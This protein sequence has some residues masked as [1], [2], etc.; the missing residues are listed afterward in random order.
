MAQGVPA[1]VGFIQDDNFVAARR[2][3]HLLLSK[4]LDLVAHH[5]NAP[6]QHR[7]P[8]RAHCTLPAAQCRPGGAV[9]HPSHPASKKAKLTTVLLAIQTGSMGTGHCRLAQ[10]AQAVG[11]SCCALCRIY[12][13]TAGVGSCIF[14]HLPCLSCVGPDEACRSLQKHQTHA[15]A[16]CVGVRLVQRRKYLSSE[17]LSSSTASL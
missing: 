16:R 5:V 1:P 12:A 17:A 13:Q 11:L 3:R 9:E 7:N 14:N 6:A 8:L 4:H 15:L 10:F 2:K